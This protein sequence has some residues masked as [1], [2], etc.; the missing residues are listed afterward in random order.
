MQECRTSVINVLSNPDEWKPGS[1]QLEIR[2]KARDQITSISKT[3]SLKTRCQEWKAML[4][5][6]ES[7]EVRVETGRDL[8]I[9]PNNQSTGE[10]GAGAYVRWDDCKE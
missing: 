8:V 2:G 9:N 3:C 5:T 10:C 4:Y 6:G 1:R 7:D